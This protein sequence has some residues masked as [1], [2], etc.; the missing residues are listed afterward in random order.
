VSGGSPVERFRESLRGGLDW[1][2]FLDLPSFAECT[3]DEK[4]QLRTELRVQLATTEVTRLIVA[5]PSLFTREEA[6]AH[7]FAILARRAPGISTAAGRTLLGLV[8]NAVRAE[9]MALERERRADPTARLDALGVID[10]LPDWGTTFYLVELLDDPDA[11]V[12]ADV[13][14]KLF[15]RLGLAKLPSDPLRGPRLLLRRLQSPSALIAAPAVEELKRLV[16]ASPL[17]PLPFAAPS[18]PSP[19]FAAFVESLDPAR[20]AID[21]RAVAL[22][23]GEE[24]LSAVVLLAE[25]L[26]GGDAT[27]A[28]VALR[29]LA[30]D[31]PIAA[32]LLAE[33]TAT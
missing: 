19:S 4:E 25:H 15:V 21:A 5:L 24:R 12:R 8:G 2:D 30:G 22:L 7:L 6:L 29:A 11:R 20:P 13:A 16:R 9:L 10:E 27:R 33:Q 18:S 14:G 26:H 17:E 3:D 31:D 1:R 28:R 32:A 23:T